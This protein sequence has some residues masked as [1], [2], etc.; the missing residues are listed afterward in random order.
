MILCLMSVA[1][2]AQGEKNRKP[3]IVGQETLS[4]N[5]DDS[6]TILM[7]DLKVEDRDDWFYPWGFTMSIYPG[8]DYSIEGSVIT[9][10]RDFTG[11][12]HVQVSVHDGED[13]SNKFD[14]VITVNPVNDKPVI[15][16]NSTLS[17]NE[18]Q[19]ITLQLGHLKVSDPDNN[20][21][22]DF[23]LRLYAG[24]N[25]TIDGNR[26]LPQPGFTGTLSVT[27]TVNDGKMESDP[28]LL[29]IGVK[30]VNSTPQITGQTP[31]QVN[32][33]ESIT[34]LLTHLT[35]VDE[36]SQYPE[37]FT[38]S[39]SSGQNFSYSGANVTPA[40]DYYG[41]LTI[42][43]TVSDGKN[44]SKSFNLSVNVIPVN[45]IPRITNLET[46]PLFCEP[47]DLSVAVT[48]TIDV[49]DV[50]GD[51]IMFAEIGFRAEGYQLNADNLAY[52]PARHA[53]I[54]SVFD[55]NTGIL[56][57]LGQASPSRYAEAI[58]SVFY[59]GLAIAPGQHKVL[60]FR[61]NDGK[62]DSEIVERALVSERS[63]VVS[64]EIP[65]G[66][67]PNGDAANDTWKIIPLKSQE[68][69]SKARIRIYNKQ[70]TLVYESVGFEKEWDGRLNGEM[71]PADTYF[72]TIDLNTRTVEGYLKGLVTILR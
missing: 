62:T 71:L 60:Y 9:P 63:A 17:T 46:A 22:D 24:I 13:E 31:L 15:T 61:V 44:T 43:V 67:T 68:A 42:P 64:L 52:V 33:D 12:L 16:G 58:R 66:F 28:Y 65:S 19:P 50:D 30:A 35:V 40:P 49:S 26:V 41:K 70:G 32:E 57:L 25:Y 11:I 20:Y 53:N 51:S 27:I 10:A 54:R 18:D 69:F 21:P 29:S 23:T 3:K 4:T 38:L 5:E 55:P 59:Q 7:T 56:S 39:L 1:S 45:D 8:S 14:L 36:D 48:E 6:I 34:I 72:Y 47:G 2:G 37:D